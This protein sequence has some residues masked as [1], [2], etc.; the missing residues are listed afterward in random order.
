MTYLRPFV[1][2]MMAPL[3]R[4]GIHSVFDKMAEL[5]RSDKPHFVFAHIISPHPPYIFGE[6]GEKIGLL[7]GAATNLKPKVSYLNQLK[8][9]SKKVESL[10]GILLKESKS[11]PIIILQADHGSGFIFHPMHNESV[12]SDTFQDIRFL[13][14]QFKILNAYYLP[15][16]GEKYLY[17]GISPVNTFRVII[18]A[19]FGGQLELLSDKSY[20]SNFILPFS[21][22]DVTDKTKNND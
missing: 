12:P 16:G 15:N 5:S 21:L 18:N 17:D 7:Q 22:I 10:V 4:N 6:N 11:P 19:Y 3:L 20:Y 14:A 13:K 1:E 8:Y 9:I 2:Q